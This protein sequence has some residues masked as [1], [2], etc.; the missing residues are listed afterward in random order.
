MDTGVIIAIVYGVVGFV[1]WCLLLYS[2]LFSDTFLRTESSP[3]IVITTLFLAI[4]W[5]FTSPVLAGY[6]IH[7]YCKQ[8]AYNRK[9]EAANKQRRDQEEELLYRQNAMFLH[10][11]MENNRLLEKVARLEEVIKL[12]M[13]AAESTPVEALHVEGTPR[14]DGEDYNLDIL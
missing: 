7:W 3:K 10:A 8:R 14:S 9:T 5:P 11:L 6:R 1:I 2:H 4:F 12:R 13:Q